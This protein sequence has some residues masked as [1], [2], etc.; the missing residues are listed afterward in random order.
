MDSITRRKFSK[1]MSYILR[2][3]PEEYGVALDEEGFAKINELLDSVRSRMEWRFLTE[4]D[5]VELAASGDNQRFEVKNGGIR[6]TYGHT[7]ENAPK[8]EAVE[9][10][11]LLYHGTAQD[12]AERVREHGLLPR[13]RCYVHL[14][15]DAATAAEVGRR[16][17]EE[18][19][20]L[21]IDAA[22]ATTDGVEFYHPIGPIY[23]AR[24]I[25]VEYIEFPE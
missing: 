25:P 10:P 17:D 7:L 9:P 22:R 2:H 15:A 8:Y 6:A 1:M 24:Q 13:D 23:L 16:H 21:K 5:L 12:L 19:V 11:P 3:R 4:S 18:P 14:S 20:I